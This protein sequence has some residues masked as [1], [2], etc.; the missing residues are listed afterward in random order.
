MGVDPQRMARAR[1]I[2]LMVLVV[3]YGLIGIAD[4][5]ERAEQSRSP[6]SGR[7][8]DSD[9]LEFNPS[10][11]HLRDNLGCEGKVR[12]AGVIGVDGRVAGIETD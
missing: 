4:R 7:R 10:I 2:C 5:F 12:F 1:R 3:L 11:C 9:Q 8:A 6:Y